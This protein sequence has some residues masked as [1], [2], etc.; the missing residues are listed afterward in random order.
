MPAASEGILQDVSLHQQGEKEKNMIWT[1]RQRQR[2]HNWAPKL[3]RF[4][5]MNL[6]NADTVYCALTT[7]MILLCVPHVSPN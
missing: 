1:W 4:W 7:T 3:S 5:N 2:G 6:G